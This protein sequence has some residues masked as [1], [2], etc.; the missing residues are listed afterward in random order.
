MTPITFEV[1]N[2]EYWRRQVGTWAERSLGHTLP[3]ENTEAWRLVQVSAGMAE[4]Y[5]ELIV[6]GG[7]GLTPG[8]TDRDEYL[9]AIADICIWSLDFC[10][11]A[12]LSMPDVL[13]YDLEPTRWERN[14]VTLTENHQPANV[15]LHEGISVLIGQLCHASVKMSQGIRRNEDHR[16]AM[17]ASLCHLWRCCYL[18]SEWMGENLNLLVPRVASGV[19]RR[20]WVENP[21]DADVRVSGEMR[22]LEEFADDPRT[23]AGMKGGPSHREEKE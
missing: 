8:P 5:S 4:E 10:W 16:G 12:R 20:N 9:D 3:K 23:A 21:D 17:L 11:T 19:T 6:R 1:G 15:V 14:F 18:L 2:L 13:T 7:W 22:A